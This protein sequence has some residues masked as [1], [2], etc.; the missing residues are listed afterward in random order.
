MKHQ[1]PI[2]PIVLAGLLAGTSFW[3]EHYVSSRA[4]LPN[5]RLRHDPDMVAEGAVQERF[6]AAGKR[7]YVLK[8]EKFE[9]FPDDDTTHAT[10]PDLQHFGKPQPLQITADTALI[11]GEGRE[12]Q[13]QGN[14][15]GHR[16]AAKDLPSLGFE[17]P[18]ITVLPDDERAFTPDPVHMTHGRTIIDGK[19]LEI[20]QVTGIASLNEVS[21]TVFS[22]SQDN[23]R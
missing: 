17:A 10:R 13:L 12:I 1:V 19:G 2:F 23:S 22:K 16:D 8:T 14:V 5:G 20:D 7:I 18:R 11:L 15:R 3:L 9:H 6:D 21:A 4:Q